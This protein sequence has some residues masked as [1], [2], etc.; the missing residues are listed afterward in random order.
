M[1]AFICLLPIPQEYFNVKKKK[2]TNLQ[3]LYKIKNLYR[4]SKCIQTILIYI[5]KQETTGNSNSSQYGTPFL[6]IQLNYRKGI[7]VSH[8]KMGS[9][10]LTKTVLKTDSLLSPDYRARHRRSSQESCSSRVMW[11]VYQA[12]RSVTEYL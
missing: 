7:E 10:K 11:E 8:L 3:N 4:F 2:K 1:L 9:G 12:P 5:F 6:T